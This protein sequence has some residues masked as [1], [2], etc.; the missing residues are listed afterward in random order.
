MNGSIAAAAALLA[1]IAIISPALAQ[2]ANPCPMTY[3]QFEAAIPHI[4]VDDC[5]AEVAGKDRF[6]RGS[7][8]GDSIHVFAFDFDGDKCLAALRS[9]DKNEFKLSIGKAK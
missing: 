2:S 6:C 3:V 7:A 1:T 9:Y 4:D 5:P 8:N